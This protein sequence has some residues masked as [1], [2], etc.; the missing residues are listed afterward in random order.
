MRVDIHY[1]ILIYCN[2]FAHVYVCFS[3]VKQ[4]LIVDNRTKKFY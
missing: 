3:N 4:K 2:M 1:L